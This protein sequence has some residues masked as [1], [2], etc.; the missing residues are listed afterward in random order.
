MTQKFQN[1]HKIFNIS[2]EKGEA[3]KPF[4][5]IDKLK[6]SNGITKYKNVNN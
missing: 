2:V 1:V 5:V 3:Y 4:P 6:Q